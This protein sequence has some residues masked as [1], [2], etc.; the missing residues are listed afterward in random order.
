MSHFQVGDVHRT[1]R[2]ASRRV[3]GDELQRRRHPAVPFTNPDA[4][5]DP[6]ASTT[7]SMNCS[8]TA[9]R[10][11]TESDPSRYTI[12][13]VAGNVAPN[14]PSSRYVTVQPSSRSLPIINY[15]SDVRSAPSDPTTDNFEDSVVAAASDTSVRGA[16]RPQEPGRFALPSSSAAF[17][18]S[19]ANR[20][21][22]SSHLEL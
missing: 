13:P 4:T 3:P 1:I 21:Q 12:G 8:A 22:P 20:I 19:N 2:Q 16:Q 18:S 6:S 9:T 10:H 15:G 5:S 17:T 7:T 14:R 11:P